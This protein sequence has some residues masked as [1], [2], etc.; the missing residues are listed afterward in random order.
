MGYGETINLFILQDKWW[1]DMDKLITYLSDKINEWEGMALGL[2][3]L[4]RMAGRITGLA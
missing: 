1:R 2:E 3:Y 4:Y